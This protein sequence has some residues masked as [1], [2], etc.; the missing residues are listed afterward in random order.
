MHY[1]CIEENFLFTFKFRL[2]SNYFV[3]I[4]V[5][6]IKN[7]VFGSKIRVKGKKTGFPKNYNG[8][9]G[10]CEKIKLIL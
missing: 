3:Y 9:N 6:Y 7:T 10:I 2:I 8:K 5:I 1:W 4:L